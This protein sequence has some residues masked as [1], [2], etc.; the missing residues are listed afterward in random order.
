MAAGLLEVLLGAELGVGDVRDLVLE[1]DDVFAVE[2]GE[3]GLV[4]EV[5]HKVETGDSAPVRQLARRVPFAL[6]EKMRELV[7]AMLKTGV[8]SESVSPW[9][10]PVVLVRKKSGELSFCVDFRR[11]NGLTRKD[12]FSPTKN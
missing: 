3:Q 5:C 7:D 2:E 11:L 4:R 6:K 12:V 8:V 10:S 9:A 1:S